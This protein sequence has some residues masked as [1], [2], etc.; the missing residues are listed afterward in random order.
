METT[1]K[2]TLANNREY[3]PD[4]DSIGKH[5]LVSTETNPH[6]KRHYTTCNAMKPEI[7]DGLVASLNGRANEEEKSLLGSADD[8]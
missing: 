2:E 8:D 7:Y 5:Y 6:I 3:F 1:S 4:L